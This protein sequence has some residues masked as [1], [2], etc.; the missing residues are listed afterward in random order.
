M[1]VPVAPQPKLNP[2]L[3]PHQVILRPLVTEKGM[4]RANRNNAYAFQVATA[5]TK[6]DTRRAV[7]ELFQVRV[8]KVAVQNRLGKVR[9]SRLRRGSTKPWKKAVVTLNA[10]DKIS[11]F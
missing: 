9:R 3:A 4:H 1:P 2:N 6:A 5:A 7:E 11:L 8:S 10:E